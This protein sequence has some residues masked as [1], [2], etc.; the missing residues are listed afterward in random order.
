MI[1]KIAL[2]EVPGGRTGSRKRPECVRLV[3]KDSEE[4]DCPSGL[5]QIPNNDQKPDADENWP[6][7]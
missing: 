4:S 3:P 6:N 1:E 2:Q 5:S 7:D